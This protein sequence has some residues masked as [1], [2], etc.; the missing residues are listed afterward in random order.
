MHGVGMLHSGQVKH[1]AR[2]S[3]DDEGPVSSKDD[4]HISISITFESTQDFLPRALDM[5]QRSRALHTNIYTGFPAAAV[6]L[7]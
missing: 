4:R 2:E 5:I 7:S 3:S 6:D 1:A